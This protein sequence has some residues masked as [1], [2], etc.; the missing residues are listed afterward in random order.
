[1]RLVDKVA[2][3]TGGA[4]GIGRGTAL[5]LAKEGARVVIADLDASSAQETI[6][7]I[8][9][10]KGEACFV[11]T[12]VSQTGQ[13]K[14][15]VDVAVNQFGRLDI[16]FNNAGINPPGSV[17]DMDE[18]VWDREMAVNLK[19]VFLCSKY[20]IPEMKKMGGGVIINTAS[21]A[22]IL[23]NF[24]AAAYCT[25]KA[26]VIMLTKQ[27]AVD[28]APFNIRVNCICPGFVQTPMIEEY[29][30]VQPDPPAARQAVETMHPIG[31]MGK[32]EDIAHAALYLVSDEASW[33]TGAAFV[34]DG[35]ISCFLHA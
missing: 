3:V 32:P 11:P 8:K 19:S 18:E 10:A 17:T 22:G 35:G 27:M 2:I 12:D 24:G 30:K 28:Y 23:A 6:G 20:V 21:V 13:I 29:L 25:S 26:G 33:V 4:S 15:T 7:H 31:R 1:M 16:L 5:L 14:N 9:K 34:I